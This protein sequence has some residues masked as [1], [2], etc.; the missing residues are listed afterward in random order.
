MNKTID[1]I[2][3]FGSAFGEVMGAAGKS[4]EEFAIAFKKAATSLIANLIQ[5]GVAA[6][7]KSS[8]VATGMAGP[9]AI[10]YSAAIGAAASS[11]FTGVISEIKAPKLAEGG[12]AYGQTLATV[13]DNPNARVDPEVI[14]PLSKLKGIMGGGSQ[15]IMLY[16]KGEISGDKIKLAYDRQEQLNRRI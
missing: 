13:G 3:A 11:M 16:V 2:S 6:A 8:L 5:I 14:A 9:L 12:L 1:I 10:A 15:A 7:V 4:S